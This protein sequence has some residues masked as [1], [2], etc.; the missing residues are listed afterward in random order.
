[1]KFGSA[2][3]IKIPLVWAKG[4]VAVRGRATKFLLEQV[5][6]PAKSDVNGPPHPYPEPGHGTASSDS[7]A[8]S[9][10]LRGETE[11]LLNVAGLR[12]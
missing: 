5:L 8:I 11:K 10:A 12:R 1:M 4:Q 7:A 3:R 6:F 2:V 9:R